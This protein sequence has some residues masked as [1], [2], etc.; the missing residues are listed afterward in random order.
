ME[1]TPPLQTALH[2]G[3]AR[4]VAALLLCLAAAAS[5]AARDAPPAPAEL[6]AAKRQA[7]DARRRSDTLAAQAAGARGKAER[8][9]TQA[10]ALAAAIEAAEAD[11]T[12]AE[13][14]VRL[15][16]QLRAEQRA[17]L[18]REQGPL[19]RLTAALQTMGRRP[20]ALAL[21]QP[22]SVGE[23]V[24]VRAL[25]A[26]TLPQ[27]RARTAGLRSEVA[28]GNALRRQA[29]LAVA[30]LRGSREDLR[31]RRLALAAF[32]ARQRSLSEGLT[33]TALDESDR[34]LALG[35]E[36]RSLAERQGTQAYQAQLRGRLA[37][38]PGPVPRPVNRPSASPSAGRYLVPVEGR[39]LAGTGELSD[40]GVHA[41]GLSFA[42]A[43]GSPAR[44]P[45]PGRI[46]YAARFRSYGNVVI[47]DH[48]GGWV[49]TLTDLASLAV[50]RGETVRRGA[51]LGT[52]G[53]RVLVELRKDG[54]PV[55]VAALID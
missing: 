46:V 24:H 42:T 22:G 48:G 30:A 44:A 6:V 40:A 9:R 12:A 14:R 37:A 28:R 19:V 36:A 29:D 23:V 45:A 55:P 17:R 35:E 52:T 31:R 38:L 39:L 2:G 20:P 10:A 13:T 32:E 34:A 26:S 47:L 21:I 50:S 16:E 49:T 54:R 7:D 43:A 51:L 27:I 5:A 33:E 4:R 18:A 3:A 53:T 15:I 11:I 8:A 1:G 41:R 25:L